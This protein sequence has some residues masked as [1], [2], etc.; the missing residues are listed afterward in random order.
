MLKLEE[1]DHEDHE[2]AQA[3]TMII[4]K[5][6]IVDEYFFMETQQM[7]NEKCVIGAVQVDLEETA[8][9]CE[10]ESHVVVMDNNCNNDAALPITLE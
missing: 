8:G 7:D 6:E 1:T 2:E 9:A 3:K 10:E 4:V 5:L